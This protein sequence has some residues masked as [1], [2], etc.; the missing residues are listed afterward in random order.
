MTLTQTPHLK[1][2]EVQRGWY[3]INAD[4]VVLGRLA[5][6]AAQLLRGKGKATYSAHMDGGDGV[7]VINAG[8]V[9]LTGKKLI[10][11]IDFRASRYPGGQTYTHYGKLLQEKP[12]RVIELAV[13]GML[14]KNRLRDRFM[15]R[16]KV[17]RG[18]E[19]GVTYK[20][21]HNVDV[22]NPKIKSGGPYV[23][24]AASGAKA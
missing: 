11:K 9:R 6:M 8:K 2:N 19:A 22:S 20:G 21:A 10:Q 16:L 12:E 15:R 4:G 24:K 13:Y 1:P 17:F 5:T 23:M 7:I 14:P 18:A 3:L